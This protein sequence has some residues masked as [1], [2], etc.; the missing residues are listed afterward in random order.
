LTQQ[1]A[2]TGTS[3]NDGTGDTIRAAVIKFNANFTDLYTNY[4]T[5]AGLSSNVATLTANNVSFVG[6]VTSANVVS[7]AQLIANLAN[8]TNTSGLSTALSSY[9]T[10]AGLSANVATLTA[11][12]TGYLGG[13]IASSYVQTANLS[14]Y[15][16]TAGLSA[17]VATLTSNSASF[18][19][20]VTAANVVS[21]AQL[22]ANLASYQTTAG[23]SANVATL[24][25]NNVSFVGSVTSANVVSNAQ[26]IANLSNY[27]TTA[28]LAANVALL[29]ANNSDNLGGVD[30]GY[31]VNTSAAYIIT[32]VHT[33]NANLVVNAVASFTNNITVSG[34]TTF[35]NTIN[36]SNNGIRFS[37]GSTVTSALIGGPTFAAYM[38]TAPTISGA[39]KLP[40]NTTYSNFTS[41]Y[42][43][44]TYRFTPTVAGYYNI[45]LAIY[46]SDVGSVTA[47][48]TYSIYKNGTQYLMTQNYNTG[49]PLNGSLT[50][51]IY[52]NGTTDYIEAYFQA[53]TGNP[54]VNYGITKAMFSGTFACSGS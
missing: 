8:Y 1:I 29:N 27:Q 35:G 49:Q 50:G 19:G 3:P 11:N 44:T 17:N 9:Q 28:G 31:Y 18:I 22:I 7:N 10:T 41:S 32:G 53:N 43:T 42:N 51:I 4:Q 14:S 25:A 5:K 16:T 20:S 48:H 23:L 36:I 34:T 21:N 54:T 2:N 15:Q 40:F 26:L 39:T 24:T 45:H 47:L 33:H 52:C 13:V 12:N 30:S 37:D 38:N 6:S 46:S